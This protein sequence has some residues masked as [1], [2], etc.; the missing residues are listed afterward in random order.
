MGR[1]KSK[2]VFQQQPDDRPVP[3]ISWPAFYKGLLLVATC[4]I[5]A[6]LI[7]PSMP[8]TIPA[9][10]IGDIADQNILDRISG[11]K[12]VYFSEKDV[13]R[14]PLVQEIIVAYERADAQ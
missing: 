12:F 14:H 11:I 8:S 4:L 13:V 7:A 5:I 3:V 2:A 10:Q 9:Y 1:K 6:Y